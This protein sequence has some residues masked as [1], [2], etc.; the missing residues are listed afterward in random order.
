M[1]AN[2]RGGME[3]VILHLC[4]ARDLQLSG[5]AA[6]QKAVVEFMRDTQAEDLRLFCTGGWHGDQESR[7]ID[8]GVK[9]RRAELLA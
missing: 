3:H 4:G 7:V 5:F 9:I 1:V 6:A 2:N 8:L